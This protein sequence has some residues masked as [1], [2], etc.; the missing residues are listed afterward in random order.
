MLHRDRLTPDRRTQPRH[1]GNDSALLDSEPAQSAAVRRRGLRLRFQTAFS[2]LWN[3]PASQPR[4]AKAFCSDVSEHGLSLE[5]SD[6]IPMGTRISLRADS[7]ALFGDA[8]VKHVAQRGAKYIV[9]VELSSLLLDEAFALIR[10][11]YSV[12]PPKSPE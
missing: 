6:P 11:A 9:G 10:D 3:E 5:T 12:P 7:G 2:V 8:R 1:P 4:Y